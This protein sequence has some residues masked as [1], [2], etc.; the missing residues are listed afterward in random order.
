MKNRKYY[1]IFDKEKIVAFVAVI[2]IVAVI[3]F[4]VGMGAHG[5]DS[6]AKCWILCKPGEGNYV[7][8][9]RDPVKGSPS[10]GTLR[11]SD[12]FLTDGASRNGFI[13]CYGIGEYGEGWIYSGFVVTEEPVEVFEQY[14]CV[15]KNRVAVRR[16]IGGPQVEGKKWL[17]NCE[18]VTVFHMAEG[19]ACTSIGYIK[20]E[21]L[22]CDPE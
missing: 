5:E 14:C 3:A 17:R 16:W 20:S 7:N 4:A 1:T 21:W 6:M 18:D 9:R 13:K 12:W 10:V 22:E 8:V 2:V 15:A 11:V 19:W